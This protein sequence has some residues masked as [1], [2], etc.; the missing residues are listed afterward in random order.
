MAAL[1]CTVVPSAA[2]CTAAAAKTTAKETTAKETAEVET[3]A[4]ASTPSCADGAVRWTSVHRERRLTEVSPVVN[5]RKDDGRI[6][7]HLG[8]VRNIVPRVGTSDD[9]VSERQVLAA[10]ARHLKW[11]DV[12]QL[13]A[14]GEESADRRRHPVEVDSLGHAGR[15]VEAGGVQVVDASF[16][17][18]CPGRDVHGSVTTWFGDVSTSLACGVDPRTEEPWIQEAYRLAC[19]PLSP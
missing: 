8:P 2:A 3:K 19:G 16:T 5:V 10:L 12:E 1:L 17:V 4:T 11:W 18:T 6:T 7:F 9:R 14:P 13:A 15:F